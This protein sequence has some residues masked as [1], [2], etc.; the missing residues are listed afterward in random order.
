MIFADKVVQ[1][2]KK[3]GWSQEELAE[4]LNVTRQSVSKWE[5]AQSIPDLEKI[6]QLAQIFGVSTD[7]LLKDELAEAEYTK[8][9]DSSS[10][11]RV[12]MEEANAFLQVKQATAG[13]IA[14]AT[15]L[16]ILSPICLFLLAAASETGMLPI[17]ENLAGGAGMIVMLLLVAVAVAMF[18]SCGGMTNPYA[19]LEAEV[20]ETEYGVSGM[21]R[22][23]QRQYRSTYT[24]YNVLGACL[25]ILSA[26][27]LFGGAF[28]SENGLFLVGRHAAPNRP[29]GDFFHRG[30][31]QLGQH[32]KAASGGRLYADKKENQLYH[33][34][35]EHRVLVRGSS[36]VPG[37][38]P[39]R[40]FLAGKLGH[41]ACGG[42]DGRMQRIGRAKKIKRT[43]QK[44]ES[45]RF[46]LPFL[47]LLHRFRL[48]SAFSRWLS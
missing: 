48:R 27:P 29:R 44:R 9:D 13:R 34:R 22:E 43:H 1:L 15:F 23:R 28:L 19:Y 47:S 32:G 16:C 38:Q 45:G 12:S 40:P 7:Y 18:I 26:I 31:R 42:G 21:V 10:V 30:R 2:R 33:R 14:F 3:S 8:S 4:K 36:R 17:R 35:G 20:F 11:R 6:L 39:P 46:R 37:M 24:R 5:G 25:C 41:M